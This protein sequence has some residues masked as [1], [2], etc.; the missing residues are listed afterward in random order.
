LAARRWPELEDHRPVLLVPLGSC[1]QHGPHLPLGTDT[2]IAVAVAERVAALASDE[3]A[4]A[5]PVTYGASGEHA[6]FP[7]TLSIG[8]EALTTLLVELVRSADQFGGV[9]LVNGH[10]GN[11]DAVAAA[12][13][14]SHADGRMALAW[15][16]VVAGGDA[17][18]GRI[19]TSI[20][21][22]VA[23]D[24]VDVDRM[25]PGR[26]EPF[27]E[28]WPALRASGL[29]TVSPN[30][31]LGDPRGASAA[32]GERLLSELVRSCSDAIAR[33]RGGRQRVD[34]APRD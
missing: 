15:W 34:R 18:A 11:R 1:E 6:G 17:H 25:A 14:R 5:P 26:T 20:V 19:E 24:E 16:P 10:G 29:A 8:T 22:A 27:A 21:L 23:P 4:V 7:G 9:V 2:L 30:G 12:V 33:W 3:C 28:L 13:S 31:V 32:E